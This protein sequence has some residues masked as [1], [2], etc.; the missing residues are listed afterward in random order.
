MLSRDGCSCFSLRLTN[1][2]AVSYVQPDKSK[3]Q[4]VRDTVTPGNHSSTQEEGKG[5]L[6]SAGEALVNVKDTVAGAFGAGPGT[7]QPK[8]REL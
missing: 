1:T 8:E 6:Q 4:E 2:R 7:Q 3:T 5:L